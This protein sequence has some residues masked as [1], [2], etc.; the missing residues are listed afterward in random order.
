MHFLVQ[1]IL[2]LCSETEICTENTLR[3]LCRI[4]GFPGLPSLDDC[5]TAA[6]FKKKKTTFL[7]LIAFLFCCRGYLQVKLCSLGHYFITRNQYTSIRLPISVL[8]FK[9]K[10]RN[11]V[12]VGDR[13]SCIPTE[14]RTSD[15]KKH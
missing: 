3:N 11:S 6:F 12:I 1:N 13:T 15:F 8:Q 14:F 7:F 2:T 5:V 9:V 10:V 4:K